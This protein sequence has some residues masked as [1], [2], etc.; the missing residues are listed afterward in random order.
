MALLSDNGIT[1]SDIQKGLQT[2]VNDVGSL[3]THIN[4][5]KWAFRKP[6]RHTKLSYLT[7]TE[8]RSQNCG[9][10]IQRVNDVYEVA[11]FYNSSSNY[12]W[13]YLRPRG[14]TANNPIEPYRMSDFLSH[15]TDSLRLYNF[16]S[17]NEE[18]YVFDP[19]ISVTI[20]VPTFPT[21]NILFSDLGLT[22][23]YFGIVIWDV[24][25]NDVLT[26]KIDDQ[27]ITNSPATYT[28]DIDLSQYQAQE[29]ELSTFIYKDGYY[30][31]LDEG[32]LGEFTYYTTELDISVI[33]YARSVPS[34]DYK[35]IE[36]QLTIDNP[37]D[38]N[39]ILNNCKLTLRYK[40]RTPSDSPIAG[41]A[42]H[43]LGTLQVDAND[44]IQVYDNATIFEYELW[45]WD[46]YGGANIW[47][48]NTSVLASNKEWNIQQL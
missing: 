36:F 24:N 40:G 9:L 32:F 45:L 14:Q 48:E 13:E 25:N 8:I 19:E 26:Y 17:I 34:T 21:Y 7:E 6:I 29:C 20:T 3:C 39:A 23:G 18:Y 11:A 41:E 27:A 43:N 12:V 38:D 33:A 22:G 10:G 30:Y 16:S 35:G 5:N 31:I 46:T 42:S 28:L 47:F 2:N 4:I 1:I 15:R 44:Y 37:T